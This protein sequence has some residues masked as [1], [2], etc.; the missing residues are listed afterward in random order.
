ML[1]CNVVCMTAGGKVSLCFRC[2]NCY[3][4]CIPR[5]VPL[6]LPVAFQHTIGKS[7]NSLHRLDGAQEQKFK[8]QRREGA[9]V[10]RGEWMASTVLSDR[11]KRY[12]TRAWNRREEKAAKKSTILRL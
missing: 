4:W 3:C 5:L 7:Q 9:D 11:D 12:V 1:A 10:K 6:A 2:F 8:K